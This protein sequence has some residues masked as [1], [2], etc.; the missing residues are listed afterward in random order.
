M[1]VPKIFEAPSIEVVRSFIEKYSFCTLVGQHNEQPIASHIP[2]KLH[3]ADD[4]EY[5]EGHIARGNIQQELFDS[6]QPL[7]AIFRDPHTYVSSSW[8]NHVNVPTWNY[9]AVHITGNASRIEGD[10]MLAS[11]E[12]LVKTYETDGYKGFQIEQMPPE[13]LQRELKGIVGF[14]LSIDKI[15]AAFKLSQNRDDEDYSNIIT[16]LQDSEDPLSR[17]IAE[18]MKKLR[19]S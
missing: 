13:M 5:L 11:I 19:T 3:V 9:I 10:E 1:Y 17:L 15:E 7:M 8:Y 12:R 6:K 18:E 14:R 2:L 16:K 4:S